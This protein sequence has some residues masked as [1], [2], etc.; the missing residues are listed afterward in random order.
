[1]PH[2]KH[3]ISNTRRDKRRTHD[4]AV[5][6]TTMVCTNCGAPVLYHRVC[7]ECGYYRGKQAVVKAT[8]E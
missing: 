8:A 1:M 2:P 7:S 5:A 6:R 4:K 3:K